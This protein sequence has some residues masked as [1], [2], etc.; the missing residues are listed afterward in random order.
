MDGRRG[1]A[2]DNATPALPPFPSLTRPG[3][4]SEGPGEISDAAGPLRLRTPAWGREARSAFPVSI[5]QRQPHKKIKR[6]PDDGAF[7]L[8]P[9]AKFKNAGGPFLLS[10]F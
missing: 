2:G 3:L 4:Q 1:H 7:L 6:P 9:A 10:Q 5:A 8:F